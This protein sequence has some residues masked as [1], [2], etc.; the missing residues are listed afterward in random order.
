MG[1]PCLPCRCLTE[2]SAPFGPQLPRTCPKLS[3]RPSRACFLQHCSTQLAIGCLFAALS[4]AHCVLGVSQQPP[5]TSAYG[6]CCCSGERQVGV[7]RLCTPAQYPCR[8]PYVAHALSALC[9]A[10]HLFRLGA[11][12]GAARRQS[13]C[14]NRSATCI[15]IPL[16]VPCRTLASHRALHSIAGGRRR[17][18]RQRFRAALQVYVMLDAQDA[19]LCTQIISTLS[20]THCLQDVALYE[21]HLYRLPAPMLYVPVWRLVD[22][23]V[24]NALEGLLCVAGLA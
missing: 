13:P 10:A 4:S 11:I 16:H 8:L 6:S 3:L 17:P 18:N 1:W 7:E 15:L 19:A 12:A 21:H 14:L 5:P 9:W 24:F 23:P 2:V 22:A 20:S